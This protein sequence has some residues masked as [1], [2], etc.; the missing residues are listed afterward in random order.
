MNRGFYIIVIPAIVTS[1][2]WL[3]FGWGWRLAAMVTAGEI[4]V[5]LGV[6]IFL[7]RRQNTQKAAAGKAG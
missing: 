1:F 5:V 7:V 2:G 6:I 4:A 3:A